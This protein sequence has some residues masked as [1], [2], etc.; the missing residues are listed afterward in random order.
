MEEE[1]NKENEYWYSV[2]VS[3]EISDFETPEEA[4]EFIRKKVKEEKF[5]YLSLRKMG[6]KGCLQFEIKRKNPSFGSV[7]EDAT[8]K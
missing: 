3:G 4:I 7:G 1:T 6:R 8:R 2:T 5:Y